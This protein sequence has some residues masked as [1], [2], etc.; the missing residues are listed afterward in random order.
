MPPHSCRRAFVTLVPR[1]IMSALD[2]KRP[3]SSPSSQSD[4]IAVDAVFPR[5]RK[6]AQGHAE[7]KSFDRNL[8]VIG[9]GS[10]PR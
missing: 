9:V 6:V 7:R 3:S 2:V 1:L 4:C 10:V 5:L 8:Y